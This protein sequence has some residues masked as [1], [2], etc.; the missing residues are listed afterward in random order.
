[1]IRKVTEESVGDDV[2]KIL[3]EDDRRKNGSH[4]EE[5]DRLHLSFQKSIV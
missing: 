4:E 3:K 1:M 2:L 5:S